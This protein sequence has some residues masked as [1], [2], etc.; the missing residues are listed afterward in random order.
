MINLSNLLAIQI[1][2]KFILLHLLI[3]FVLF[4]INSYLISCFLIMYISTDNKT[5]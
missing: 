2:L 3:N 4:Y 5:H 1:Y